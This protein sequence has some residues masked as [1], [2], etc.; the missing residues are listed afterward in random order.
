MG[1]EPGLFGGEQT[2]GEIAVGGATLGTQLL[3]H[4][5]L[6]ELFSTTTPSYSAQG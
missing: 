4:G 3:R 6:D 2:D 5:I 1:F